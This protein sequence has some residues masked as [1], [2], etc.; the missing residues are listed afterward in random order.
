MPVHSGFLVGTTITIPEVDARAITMDSITAPGTPSVPMIANGAGE[1][2][3]AFADL[4]YFRIWPIPPVLDVQNPKRNVP[5]PFLLWNAFLDQVTLNVITPTGDTGL[6]IDMV[7]T[8]VFNRLDLQ[9][10][11]VTIGDT[12]PF[13]IDETYDFDF[14]VGSALVRFIAILADILPLQAEND[15]V[16]ELEWL[17]DVQTNYDGSENRIALRMRPRRTFGIEI[18]IL[19]DADRKILYDKL[20]KAVNLDMYVGSY[21]YQSRLKV[22]TVPADNKLYT[23]VRRADLRVGEDVMIITKQGEQFL[24]EIQGVFADHVTTTTAFSQVIPKGSMVCAAFTGRFPNRSG[25]A[26]NSIAGEMK[27]KLLLTDSRPQVA[28]PDSGV[29]VPTFDGKPLLLKNPLA[30]G[31]TP[32]LFDAGLEVIDNQTGRPA[33]YM[34]WTQPFME[35]TRKYL[36]QTLWDAD[37]IEFWRS[38]LDAIRGSQKSFYTPTYRQD[39][40]HTVGGVFSQTQIEVDGL[41][42]GS[43]YDGNEPYMA[44]DI[45]TDIGT[46]QV[47]VESSTPTGNT[48]IIDFIDPIPDDVSLAVVNRVSYLMLVRL[49]SDKVT[50]THRPTHSTVDLALRMAVR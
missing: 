18:T 39:Q 38:F 30:D 25:L 9:T 6:S 1:L 42:F 24:Y 48:T 27:L 2:I 37:D 34:D 10:V 47:K 35:G 44:L 14:G 28:W 49:G 21:Q 15:I 33:Y 5:I 3:R 36:I 41:T 29:S 13:E 43:L 26:M 17:T 16:E 31:E 32:E 20:F 45:E 19:S 12:A 50:L 7:V 11:N 23:N 46:Y 8:T 4:F 40:V 22:A